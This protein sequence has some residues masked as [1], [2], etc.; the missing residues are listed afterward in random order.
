MSVKYKRELALEELRRQY[1]QIDSDA[2]VI[3][4]KS[5][6]L[7][8]NSSIVLTLFA[9][10]QATIFTYDKAPA[11]YLGLA[12]ILVLFVIMLALIIYIIRPQSYATPFEATNKSVKDTILGQKSDNDA[13]EQLIVNYIARI[14]NNA[15]IIEKKA[16]YLGYAYSLFVGIMILSI[17]FSFFVV[18]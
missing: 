3:D 15:A 10:L 9:G 6:D 11:Y 2:D 1:S 14:Q 4:Q 13:V 5:K 18:S 7:V 8:A 12:F 16:K 17:A